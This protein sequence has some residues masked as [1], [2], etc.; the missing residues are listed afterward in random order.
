MCVYVYVY[1]YVTWIPQCKSGEGF[2]RSL[3]HQCRMEG[4]SG[5]SYRVGGGTCTLSLSPVPWKRER[6][7]ERELCK[8]VHVVA[9][10]N[11]IKCK[12]YTRTKL[13]YRSICWTQNPLNERWSKRKKEKRKKENKKEKYNSHPHP[14][15]TWLPTFLISNISSLKW[16][17]HPSW[18][19]ACVCMHGEEWGERRVREG[20][21]W[22]W[23]WGKGEDEG[24]GME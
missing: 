8:P 16:Q 6:E 21:G 10:S 5:G 23:G 22:G 7:R 13:P 15:L 12:S 18:V 17:F 9:A 4:G 3:K 19:T 20:W 24:K 1:M 2:K 14:P 11:R